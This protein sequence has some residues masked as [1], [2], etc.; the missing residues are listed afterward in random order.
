LSKQNNVLW[1]VNCDFFREYRDSGAGNLTHRFTGAVRENLG[2]AA[3]GQNAAIPQD[4]L[5]SVLPYFGFS[6]L[7]GRNS[8]GRGKNLGRELNPARLE[9]LIE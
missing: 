4:I 9:R 5:S 3:V 8:G 6:A 1:D 7:S 2:P